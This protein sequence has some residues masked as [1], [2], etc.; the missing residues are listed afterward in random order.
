MFFDMIRKREF[1]IKATVVCKEMEE[2][3]QMYDL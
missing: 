2:V 1:L 3:L